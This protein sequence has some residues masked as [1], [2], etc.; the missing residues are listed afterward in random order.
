MNEMVKLLDNMKKI[1]VNDSD[2]EYEG[3][4]VPRVT[5]I[6]SRCIHNDSLMYWANNLGFKHKSYSKTLNM[7]SR[8]GSQ[9]H[10]CIDNYIEACKNDDT[11]ESDDMPDDMEP[12]AVSAYE[13]FQKWYYDICYNNNAEVIYHEKTIICKYFGGTL[14][15]LY[16]INGKLYLVDYKTSNHVR[17]NYCLQLAAYRIMLREVLHI[18]IDGAMIIQLDKHGNGYNEYLFDFANP[19]ELQFMNEC[20]QAF[21][22]LVYSYYNIEYIESKFDRLYKGVDL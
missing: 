20:E 14:D 8:I 19:E 17:F 5:A 9:C 7:A 16:K 15:G 4:K 11:Y 10:S 13:S 18:E 22:S 12:E 2:Y 1:N 21:M 3:R 6:L